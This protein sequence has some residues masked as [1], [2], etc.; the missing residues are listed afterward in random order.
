MEDKKLKKFAKFS[1]RLSVA[2][3]VILFF[4]LAVILLFSLQFNNWFLFFFGLALLL[5]IPKLYL[6]VIEE[7]EKHPRIIDAGGKRLCFV[8][9][10]GG[11]LLI[12]AALYDFFI[13]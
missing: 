7:E 1:S 9:L 2:I 13:R 10:L 8:F 5:Y 11:C 4:Y 12:L 6:E 3:G